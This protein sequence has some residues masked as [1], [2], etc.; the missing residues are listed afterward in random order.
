[1]PGQ[2]PL[3]YLFVNQSRT[4]GPFAELEPDWTTQLVDGTQAE[5]VRIPPTNREEALERPQNPVSWT[6]DAGLT[7]L[8][9]DLAWA[10]DRSRTLLVTGYWRVE[11][12]HP[13]RA[14]WFVSPVYHLLNEQG[15][16][17]VNVSPHGQWGYEWELGDVYVE[18]VTLP[19]PDGLG[20]GDY[21]L[22][23]GLYDPIHDISFMLNGS[24]GRELFY[25]I[26][27]LLKA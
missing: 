5:L 8:G 17:E 13:D 7:L 25:R 24:D 2:E 23:I 12:L 15:Q 21:V 20:P 19:L 14:E 10:D 4:P 26:P 1:L 3:L 11:E 27:V 22:A 9:Y 6:S 16:I 18:A